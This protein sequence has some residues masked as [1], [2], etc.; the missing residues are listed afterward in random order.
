MQANARRIEALRRYHSSRPGK[1]RQKLNDAL[2]RMLSGETVIL[3]R[4]RIKFNKSQLAKEAEVSI[5]TLL[6]KERTGERRFEDVL[7]RLKVS[8]SRQ[9]LTKTDDERDQK[10]AELRVI[11]VQI[12]NDKLNLARQLD[13]VALELLMT[14]QEADELRQENQEQLQE[15]LSLRNRV[16]TQIPRSG[17]RRKR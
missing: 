13:R 12:R 11:V 16:V 5:H 10:I 1:T 17:P 7:A 3:D 8:T 6:K 15:L 14:K 2:D 9:S 4:K